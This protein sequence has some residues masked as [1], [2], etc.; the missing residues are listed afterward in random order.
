MKHPP[1]ELNSVT[2]A[3]LFPF[4]FFPGGLHQFLYFLHSLGLGVNFAVL[5][6]FQTNL[7]P[8]P[9]LQPHTEKPGDKRQ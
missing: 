9:P 8:V 1:P 4:R 3:F 7:A 2:A 6:N 5:T